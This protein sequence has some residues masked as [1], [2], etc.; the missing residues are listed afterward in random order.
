MNRAPIQLLVSVITL[1]AVAT[2]T[3][4]QESEPPLMAEVDAADGM[5]R[6][7][8]HWLDRTQWSLHGGA[9]Y[10]FETDIDDGGDFSVARGGIG[11][12]TRTKFNEDVSLTFRLDYNLDAYDFSSAASSLGVSDPWDEIHTVSL[13]AVLSV[14][15]GSEWTLFGG[16][17][18]QLS[19]EAG[20]DFSDAIQGGGLFAVSYRVSDTLT[21]GGGLGVVTQIEDDVRVFPVFVLNWQITDT[22]S[23]RNTSASGA[24]TRSGLELVCDFDPN[25]EAAF[26][27]AYQFKRFRLDDRSNAADEGVGE[28]SAIPIWGRLTYRLSNNGRINFYAGVVLGGELELETSGGDGIGSSDYDPAAVVGISGSIRF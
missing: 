4:A 12:T 16:P 14:D 13:G 17:I 11:F 20:A 25:W 28:D 3:T 22:L 23:V 10:Q 6:Q 26:G 8:S 1:A 15:A 18:L 2:D 19:G 24:G 9:E 5:P 7:G 21:I 27:G